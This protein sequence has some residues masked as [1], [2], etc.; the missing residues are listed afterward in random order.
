MKDPATKDPREPAAVL[1]G[2]LTR[3]ASGTLLA[4]GLSLDSLA[5]Q[6]GT[7]LYVYSRAQI[8]ATLEQFRLAVKAATRRCAMPSRPTA[9]SRSWN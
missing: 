2:W 4:E 6:F 9:T 7:P 5:Q 8:E 3:D 1:P